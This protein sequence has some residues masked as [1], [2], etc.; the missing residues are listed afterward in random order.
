MAI[1]AGSVYSELILDSSKYEK[2]LNNAEKQADV[3]SNGLKEI[4]TAVAAAFTAKAIIDFG[5]KVIKA[6]ADLQAMDA[7]F[8]QVFKDDENSKAIERIN[9]QVDDMGIHA[10]RLTVSWNKFGGQVKGAGMDATQAMDATDKATR[11]AADAAAYFDR[12]LED[13]SS[14]LASFMKGNFEAGDAI[15]VFTNATQMDIV[16]KAELG[17]SWKDL[18]EAERQWL[19][20]DTVE[21]TYELNGAMGQASREAGAYENVMGNLRATFKRLYATIGEPILE[22]FIVVVQNVTDKAEVLTQ[23]IQNGES[24]FN[25][26]GDAINFAKENSDIIIPV[27]GGVTAAITAQMIINTVAKGYAA[28]KLATEGTT[29]AQAA[30]N[31]VMAANPFGIIA[32]AIGALVAA[33]IALYKNWDTVKNKAIEMSE[34]VAMAWTNMKISVINAISTLVDKIQNLTG[35]IP[36]VGKALDGVKEKLDNMVDEVKEDQRT[37]YLK[38]AYRE[39]AEAYRNELNSME[40]K[41]EITTDVIANSFSAAST[42]ASDAVKSTGKSTGKAVKETTEK[43]TDYFDDMASKIDKSIDVIDKKLELW[44]LQNKATEESTEY[45]NKQIEVQKEKLNLLGEQIE[46]TKEALNAAIAEYGAGSEE[47]LKYTNSLLDLQIQ[48]EKLK[49]SIEKANDALKN[50]RALT[51]QEMNDRAKG[52]SALLAAGIITPES[53]KNAGTNILDF[54]GGNAQGTDYWRGGLTWVGEEGPEIID[55]PRGSK[56]YT[57]QES[58]D[59][60]GKTKGD[61]IQNITINSPTP[62]TP[63]ESAR[64]Y[65]QASQ[66]LAME[67]GN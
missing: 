63:S 14:S 42:V 44:K 13:T 19:L 18:T 58:K 29:I 46:I 55:L 41:T 53:L 52:M 50:Q 8:D 67:W 57:N 23:K 65:K 39:R 40:E 5:D 6:S 20:L 28:F 17:K 35:W 7:Q 32:L 30:L 11:L 66:Q 25:R 54:I 2:A 34:N 4:G 3:F 33:G 47:A 62:L 45:L 12:S 1:N 64:R 61:I 31:A 60:V 37:I 56:V 26:F 27:L 22:G 38:R 16:A 21:K 15:G 49:D 10:D 51:S 24:I 36:G 9:Q 48:Q 43:I 59:I